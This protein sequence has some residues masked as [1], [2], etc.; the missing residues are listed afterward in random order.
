M[1][2]LDYGDPEDTFDTLLREIATAV[3][4]DEAAYVLGFILLHDWTD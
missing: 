2:F 4:S 1:N 3:G